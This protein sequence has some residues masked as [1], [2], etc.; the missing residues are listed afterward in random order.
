LQEELDRELS[1]DPTQ[2]AFSQVN[3]LPYLE[4]VL[5]E[6][7]RLQPVTGL[8]APRNPPKEGAMV[9]SYFIPH[10]NVVYSSYYVLQNLDEKVWPNANKY[11][12]ERW[13]NST[14]EQ[15]TE[16]KRW[17]APFSVG[18]RSCIGRNLA[19]LELKMILAA[20]IKTYDVSW[21]KSYEGPDSVSF[22]T[23]LTGRPKCG[24]IMVQL[25]RRE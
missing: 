5:N 3:G 6:S 10:G 20:F 18:P 17:F 25:K 1:S 8:P 13:I 15:L 21:G 14:P 19:W 9:G 4:A 22:V 24:K 7:L 2:I 16:M 11:D 12:P 23:D